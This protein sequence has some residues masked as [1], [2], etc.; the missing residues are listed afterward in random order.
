MTAASDVSRRDLSRAVVRFNARVLGIT[1]GVIAGL[2]LFVA[3]IVLVLHG[4]TD[5]GPMLGLLRHFFPG[6]TVTI[7]GAFVGAIWAAGTFYVVGALFGLSFGRWLLRRGGP[8]TRGDGEEEPGR[9]V[10]LLPPL[11]VGLTTGALLASGLFVATNW[12]VFRGGVQNPHLGLLSYYLP[13][14]TTDFAGSLIGAFWV[15]LYGFATAASVAWI[16]DRIVLARSR[17]SE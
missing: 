17:G 13:G 10:A 1:L 16:Y 5:P 15:L 2:G 6:Y 8:M 4:G 7:G 14:Y 9:G 3:T 12:L 11:P